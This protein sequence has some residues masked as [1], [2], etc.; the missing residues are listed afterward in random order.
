[1]Y[2]QYTGLWCQYQD[3]KIH[4]FPSQMLNTAY[5]CIVHREALAKEDLRLQ[6]TKL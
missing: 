6:Q 5:V 3:V 1:M 2:V 4:R